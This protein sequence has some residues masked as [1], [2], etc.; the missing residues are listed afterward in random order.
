MRLEP[1]KVTGRGVVYRIS[2]AKIFSYAMTF[3]ILIFC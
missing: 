2:Y 3:R 1:E